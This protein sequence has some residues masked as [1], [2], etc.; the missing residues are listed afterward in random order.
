[1]RIAVQA[2]K[3]KKKLFFIILF[4]LNRTKTPYALSIQFTHFNLA[5]TLVIYF[6]FC[7]Y[8]IT[9]ITKKITCRFEQVRGAISL[10]G[11]CCGYDFC[12]S[13]RANMHNNSLELFLSVLVLLEFFLAFFLI[14]EVDHNINIFAFP[15][16]H[17]A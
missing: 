7:E 16:V 13:K 8:N 5:C 14:Q 2:K 6:F 1:M 15:D 12:V 3:M 4:I 9:S 17:C 11:A 10:L